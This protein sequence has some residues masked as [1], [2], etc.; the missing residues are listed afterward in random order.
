MSSTLFLIVLDFVLRELPEHLGAFMIDGHRI[1]YL[2]YADDLL[3][4]AWDAECLLAVL[5]TLQSLI[6]ATGLCVNI[7][8]SLPFSW[9]RSR[10][11]KKVLL[12]E[13]AQFYIQNENLKN[14]KSTNR[15][16]YLGIEFNPDGR[17]SY[18][19]KVATDLE[20][21][22]KVPLRKQ[23]KLYFLRT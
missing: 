23:Q 18:M 21:L 16:K 5:N 14:L 15:F 1:A 9:V 2:A 8:K 20:T 10:K 17:S 6:P 3:L 22:K 11:R 12:D 7:Q 4:L 13:A 19:P